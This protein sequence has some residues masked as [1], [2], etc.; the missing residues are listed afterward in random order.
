MNNLIQNEMMKLLAKKRLIII[1]IIVG[2]LVLMFTYAQYK[3]VEEQ[4]EKLGTDDWRAALQQQIIDTQN[5]LGSNRM[6]DEWREQLQVS[7]KQQQYYLDHD[8]NPSEPGAATFTRMFLENAIDLFIP[9]LIMIVASDMVSSESSQGTIKLLLTRPVERWKIL[10]SK[11]V[12]LLLSVSIIVAMTA[13]LSYLLSGIVFGYQGW[14]APVI[15]GF[16]LNGADVDVSQVRL[17]EQWKFLLMD[18]GLVW[19]V[20]VVVGTLSFM[21]SVLVRSTP[22]GMGI[23]LAALISG[24]ILNNM[25]SSWESAKYFFMVNL[26]LTA[27]ISGTAPP[28]EGMTLLSS[29]ITLLVWWALALIVSFTV[30][31]RRDVY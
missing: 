3:Q 9:L 28:I 21:L 16:E 8:I 25:V 31:T 30:F 26:K 18:L 24:A 1:G 12:T 11:Y 22:A 23:M 4:R 10:L 29:V 15:T 19:L 13:L 17:V 20:A 7:L 27:Y 14:G 5:R 2:I 6:L